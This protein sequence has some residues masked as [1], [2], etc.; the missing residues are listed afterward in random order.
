MNPRKI[1]SA[2]A[3]LIDE[4]GQSYGGIEE[5]FLRIAIIAS[6]VTKKDLTQWDV[7]M[8]LHATKLAR[9]AGTGDKLDNYLDGINYLAFAAEMRDDWTTASDGSSAVTADVGGI[10]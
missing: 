7:A 3:N 9:M 5:N 6:A 2:S 1:L 8:V 10:D 4:R